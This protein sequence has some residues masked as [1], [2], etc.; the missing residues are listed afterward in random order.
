MIKYISLLTISL[1][2]LFVAQSQDSI[3]NADFETW[4]STTSPANWQSTND[5]L[6]AGFI[7]CTQTDF[8]YSGDHALQ[9]KT[10]N[11][12]GSPIPG[13]LALGSVG[14]GYT[15]G[16]VPFS[17]KPLSLNGYIVHPS[18]GDE[19]MIIAQFYKNG[20]EIGSGFWSTSDSLA[21]FTPF[22]AAISFQSSDTPDTLNITVLTDQYTIGSSMILD[23][24]TFELPTT[25][26]RDKKLKEVSIY[27]NPCSNRLFMDLPPNVPVE[28]RMYDISGKLVMESKNGEQELNTSSL[29]PGMYTLLMDMGKEAIRQKVIKQ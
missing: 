28:V 24:L 25:A 2:I 6:P 4:Y 16:G 23:A 12:E 14:M 13:V 5:L 10:I 18:T 17:A 27:P 21:E 20:E 9:L 7:T 3:P 26:T 22:S 29:T 15:Y 1:A 8:S 11:M 19:V